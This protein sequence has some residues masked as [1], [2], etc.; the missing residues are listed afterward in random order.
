[1]TGMASELPALVRTL[2][3]L[4][5]VIAL[6]VA[7]RWLLARPVGT[8]AEGDPL[9]LAGS[10]ALDARTRLVVVRRGTTE[11]VLAVGPHGVS[12]LDLAVAQGP[13]PS[14]PP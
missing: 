8:R 10:L 12:R 4:T 6:V 11:L 2:L 5:A 9:V 3:A 14:V 13:G 1:M 7:A